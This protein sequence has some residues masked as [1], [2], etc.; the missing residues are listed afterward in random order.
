MNTEFFAEGQAPL[1]RAQVLLLN[2]LPEKAKQQTLDD[3]RSGK[4]IL[5]SYYSTF[6]FVIANAATGKLVLFD[7][8]KT[9]LEGAIPEE[10]HNATLQDGWAVCVEKIRVGFVADATKTT[11]QSGVAYASL[12]DAW[13][14]ALRNGRFSI[15]QSNGQPRFVPALACGTKAASIAAVGSQDAY[16]LDEPMYFW[17][18]KTTRFEL[19]PADSEAFASPAGANLLEITF[20]GA[21]IHPNG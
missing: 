15:A 13:P 20:K 16:Q 7:V 19:W 1:T 14:A 5:E 10:W 17:E 8:K 4:I 9:F 2:Q 21:C 11:G 12:T 18:K 6:R 3:I